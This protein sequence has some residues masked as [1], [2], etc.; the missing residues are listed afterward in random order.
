MRSFQPQDNNCF[1][2]FHGWTQRGEGWGGGGGGG[3]D[4][5]LENHKLLKVS[6]EILVKTPLEKQLDAR[7]PIASRGRSARPSVRSH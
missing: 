4:L 7:G 6:L 5:N 2:L 1:S 3:E